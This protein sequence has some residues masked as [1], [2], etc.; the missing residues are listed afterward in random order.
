MEEGLLSGIVACRMGPKI[1][2]L[3][4][5]NDTLVFGDAN[6]IET[7]RIQEIFQMYKEASRQMVNEEKSEL[8]FSKTVPQNVRNQ[9][10][11]QLGI[12]EV[13]KFNKY[14]GLPT[15]YGRSKRDLLKDIKDRLSTRINHWSTKN[16][17][18]AGREVLIEVV[19]QAIPTFVIF[20]FSKTLCEDMHRD[21]ANCW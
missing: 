9:I 10:C 16:L 15:L 5:A 1:S 3:L 18:Q 2:H 20:K 12:K 17:S 21:L 19:G 7:C 6:V 8:F 4:F 14:L 13:M 11:L